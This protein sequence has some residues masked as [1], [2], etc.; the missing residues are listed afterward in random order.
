MFAY[1]DQICAIPRS[2]TNTNI[3]CYKYFRLEGYKPLLHFFDFM[4]QN[5][6]TVV[7]FQPAWSTERLLKPLIEALKSRGM[8]VV[9]MP[10]TK[11]SLKGL[12][13]EAMVKLVEMNQKDFIGIGISQGSV[14]LNDL[15]RQSGRT[16]FKSAIHVGTPM[17]NRSV[18]LRMLQMLWK[19]LST[20]AYLLPI[21]KSILITVFGGFAS[22]I[23]RVSGLEKVSDNVSL[24]KDDVVRFLFA[25]K[26]PADEGLL[27]EISESTAS[28]RI[29]ADMLLKTIKLHTG[30]GRVAAHLV[31]ATLERFHSNTGAIRWFK[32]VVKNTDQKKAVHVLAGSHFG[33]LLEEMEVSYL[34]E[35]ALQE[36]I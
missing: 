32:K 19:I 9:V 14:V 33:I 5:K 31:R 8:T 22:A 2:L 30:H 10:S 27:D 15:I 26:R 18:N 25:G 20:K 6:K 3:V 16:Y 23:L 12:A 21:L 28:A 36:S 1:I 29:I 35:L 11:K 34:A 17:T 7:I 24:S 13:Q 4:P